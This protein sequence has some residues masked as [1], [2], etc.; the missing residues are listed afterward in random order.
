MYE[1]N[2]HRPVNYFLATRN[3]A[4]LLGATAV[5]ATQLTAFGRVKGDFLSMQAAV[6]VPPCAVATPSAR[7]LLNGLGKTGFS[8]SPI[9]LPRPEQAAAEIISASLCESNNVYEAT[10]SFLGNSTLMHDA[11]AGSAPSTYTG[12]EHDL[13]DHLCNRNDPEREIYGGV[14]SRIATAYVL[15]NP[16][17]RRYFHSNCMGA[18]DPFPTSTGQC[19]HATSVVSIELYS[20]AHDAAIGG[21]GV[22]PPVGNMLYRLLALAA[23]SEHDRR[24]NN[25]L[26]FAN[27][28]GRNATELC[29]DIYNDTLVGGAVAAP[30]PPAALRTIGGEVV[31]GYEAVL[32]AA[33]ACSAV[34][35][36]PSTQSPPP[37]PPFPNWDF[38]HSI[39]AGMGSV[40]PEV[41]AC[42]NVHSFGHF[43]QQSAFGIP[44]VVHPFSWKPAHW[45]WPG[46]WFYYALVDGKMQG[47]VALE[48]NH[49]N[50]L[51]LHGAYRF[52][53]ASAMVVMASACCGYW[54]GF[55]AT[56]LFVLALIRWGGVRNKV[57]GNFSTLLSPRLGTG[58]SLAV[59]TSLVVWVYA[60]LLD[61]WLPA[62]RSYTQSPS[63]AM[64]YKREIASVFV[65]SDYLAGPWEFLVGYLFL[66]V[67]LGV[68]SYAIC[69]R[70]CAAPADEWKRQTAVVPRTPKL[71]L[72]LVMLQLGCILCF[73]TL[74]I[75]LSLIHI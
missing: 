4:V 11:D 44:D 8:W 37:P 47:A 67:P 25:N 75:D 5:L 36:T 32:Q 57:T 51:K 7:G 58:G 38:V 26:C 18:N 31:P 1:E 6:H 73:V 41:D 13:V 43:D 72:L 21:Y 62:A 16:A 10:A 3:V 48:D 24:L 20:A 70:R 15:A 28:L 65:T 33:I 14:H 59:A 68:L 23:I 34:H 39:E 63:C 2:L 30:P 64:W 9:G 46:G 50:A 42:R 27:R 53:V 71:E 17:F 29:M 56:P 61:P 35:A 52:A 69:L 49:I 54:I 60:S 19:T 55:G 12:A 45:S 74:A 22:L 40:G 66:L